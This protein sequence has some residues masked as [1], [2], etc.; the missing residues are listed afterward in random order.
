MNKT[1]NNFLRGFLG[2]WLLTFATAGWAQFKDN[3]E[4]A[5]LPGG[6]TLGESLK[7]YWECGFTIQARGGACEKIIGTVPVPVNWNEQ[8]V[9]LV[10]E[11]IS[12]YAKISFKKQPGGS[13]LMVVRIN[14]LPAGE[15]AEVVVRYEVESAIQ[16]PPEDT[17]RFRKATAGEIPPNLRQYLKPSIGIECKDKEILKLARELGADAP[18]AWKEVEEV[19]DWVQKEIRYENGPMKGALAALR[20]RTG[21]CE[22]LA[23]VFIAVCRA[24]KI[25]ARVVW[26]PDHCYAEFY[27]VDD[28]GNGFWFP[29]QVAGDKA[30]GEMPFQY[31]ILQK[32]DN[33]QSQIKR[34]QYY[35]YLPMEVRG[36]GKPS[37]REI[38]RKVE[39]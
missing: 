3:E 16:N 7:Q 10:K 23:S 20:D 36:Q 28:E 17:T 27:L 9:R 13:Q 39:E 21:D 33:F 8:K 19:Y 30:F 4:N 14:T 2:C 18:N 29:C 31:I 6:V 25:P 24:K 38:A 11:N 34:S 22:E 37:V 32:G 15:K 5:P 1:W 12:P 35:R 26:V